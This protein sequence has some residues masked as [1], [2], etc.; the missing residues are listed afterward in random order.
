MTLIKASKTAA[1]GP[2]YPYFSKI[3]EKSLRILNLFTPETPHLSQK[4]IILKT[5]INPASTYRLVVTLVQ[6]GYLK[7]DPQ[8]KLIKLGSAALILS[9]TVIASFDMLHVL[10]PAIDEAFEKY[11]VTIDSGLLDGEKNVFLYRREAPDTL[12]FKLPV[13]APNLIHCSAM[14]KA[15][16]AWMPEDE[17]ART[18]D[19]LTL[20]RRTP[21]TLTSRAALLADLQRTRERGYSI[22]DE[23]MIPGLISLGAPL[24]KRGGGVLGAI[25]FDFATVQYTLEEAEKRFV[26]ALLK[27]VEDIRPLLPR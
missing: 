23:E 4:D 9:N 5:R 18:L 21:N 26:P 1:C 19:G 14:G 7:K 2:S 22:N 8:T 15:I 16:L 12:V 11:K 24:T 17:L 27:L 20:I 13:S 6:L 10:K 3:V 25:T